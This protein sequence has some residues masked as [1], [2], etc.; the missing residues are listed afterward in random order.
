ME[1]T[2]SFLGNNRLIP[3]QISLGEPDQLPSPSLGDAFDQKL[4][5]WLSQLDDA[6]QQTMAKLH[7]DKNTKILKI[8][9][10]RNGVLETYLF[11]RTSNAFLP[12]EVRTASSYSMF[13]G[14]SYF[15][16]SSNG[17]VY[18]DDEG[19]TNDAITINHSWKTGT[20]EYQKGKRYMQ[21][22]S[23]AFDGYMTS[24]T[25]FEFKVYL[26]GSSQPVYTGS[27]TDDLIVSNLGTPLG[28]RGVGLSTIGGDPLG[29]LAFP[30]RCEILL[31][32][33]SGEDFMFEWSCSS[34]GGYLQVDSYLFKSLL[35]RSNLRTRN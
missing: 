6:S 24:G 17:I 23:F 20:I 26:D 29:T 30:Y 12:S 31:T 32:G 1:G 9:G 34:E 35:T 13:L 21:G 4:R 18:L 8:Q 22:H 14:R 10:V 5:P 3:I 16:H 33:L 11:D 27:F 19:R 2:V 25:E 7:Y 28:S 15:G